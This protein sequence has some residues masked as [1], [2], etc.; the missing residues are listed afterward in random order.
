MK[1]G[2]IFACLLTSSIVCAAV[3][4]DGWYAKLF[5]GYAYLPNNVSTNNP[6]YYLS[7]ASFNS[8][9]NA[10]G[11]FGYKSNPLRFEGEFTYIRANVSEFK[12][13]NIK[14][15]G[16]GGDASV[17]MIMANIYYDFPEIIHT[18]EPFLGFGIGYT[19]VNTDFTSLGPLGN[20]SYNSSNSVFTYQGTAGLTFNYAEHFSLDL[21]YRYL[22]TDKVGDLGKIFQA[23]LLI[24]G[25]T[26]RF[27]GDRY[28]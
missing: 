11:S 3:P 1:I 23:N 7:N 28:K 4:I 19:W 5:G 17:P 9:Y 27:D 15:T 13:N 8:G 10:G 18:I 2:F 24:A 12:V 20:T 14:Q 26:Y 25:A 22:G 21:A 6:G 16:V